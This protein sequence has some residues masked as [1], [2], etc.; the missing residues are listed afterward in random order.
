MRRPTV[1]ILCVIAAALC[2]GKVA[3]GQD[4]WYR[5]SLIAVGASQA[6]DTASSWGGH[7]LN[8]VLGTGRFGG[9]Q[10]GIKSAVVGSGIAAQYVAVR[11]YPRHRKVATV[12]NFALAAA[13]TAVAVRNWRLK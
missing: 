10:V 11:Q 9:R 5:A 7:E 2:F 13:T 1:V 12:V 4:R 8:P 6:A 3:C